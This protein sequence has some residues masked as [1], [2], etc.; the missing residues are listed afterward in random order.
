M[1]L[2]TIDRGMTQAAMARAKLRAAVIGVGIYGEVHARAYQ[3]E[4]RTEL[5][6]VWSRSKERARA[7]GEKFDVPHTT[8]LEQIAN[9]DQI[10]IVSIATPDFAHTEPALMM[11]AAGKH[12]LIEKPMAMS[13]T[14][15]EKIIAARNQAGTKLMVNFHNRWYP[16]IA[17]AKKLIDA[18]EIGQPV[19]CYARLSDQIVVPTEWLN[20]AEQSG[21][22]WFLFPHLVDILR[23]LLA[24]EVRSV[25]AVG[26]RGVLEAQGIDCY[27]A[28]Q[29]QL[30]FDDAIA[31]IESSW[32]LPRSWRSVIDFKID[33][34]GAEGKIGI[35][36]DREG[37]EVTT[38]E[39]HETPFI[40][41][42]TTTE[43]LPFQHFIDC[44]L[45]DQAPTCSGE[46]G[47]AVTRVIEQ[48]VQSLEEG[49]LC[50]L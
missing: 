47:L 12:V 18:G 22:Q 10:Q 41:D 6:C 27:D 45:N 26:C 40:L 3:R 37:I 8:E 50:E 32:I 11:L 29:A 9:D 48:I 36:A 15:C 2:Q 30:V 35:E 38:N 4:E 46:D 23:W 34:L 24:Q 31:T 33:V 17:H 42:P 44:I 13:V 1:A 20:W 25:F 14:E 39:C 43:L 21:P 28:V 49:T 19:C 5:A 16:P 7:A